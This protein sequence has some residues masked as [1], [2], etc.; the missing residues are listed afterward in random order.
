LALTG[1]NG[2]DRTFEVFSAAR[3]VTWNG[4]AVR[5][6]ATPSG[7]LVGSIPVAATVHLPTL[8]HWRH[9][10]ESPEAAPGFDDS[11]WQVADKTTTN[12]ITPVQ[13]LPVLYA[14]DYGFHTGNIWYRGHFQATGNET[15]VH[16]VSDSGGGAQAFSAWIN[17]QFLGSSTTGSADF[18]FPAG[19]LHQGGDNVISVLTVNMGHEEDYNSTNANKTARGLTTAALLGS[20]STPVTWRIQG[21]LGGEDIQDPVRGPLAY[22]GLFG[23]REGWDLPSYPDTRWA[24]VT[25]PASDT[26]AGVSWYRTSVSLH[27]PPG[28]DTSIGVTFSDNPSRRY[29]ALLYVNGWQLGDYVNYLGPEHSFP[30]PN[31]ILRTDGNNTIAIA[32]WNLD[33]STG[34][35]GQVSLTNYGSYASSLRV[36]PVFSPGYHRV[37][38]ASGRR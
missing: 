5:T 8:T 12:S 37:D 30:I 21:N 3:Q 7:S 1:D 14:D 16:L 25:L 23:E 31:G 9:E 36:G 22:G 13:S 19:S 18:V 35:L 28:Q 33:S 6:T 2:T 27:L 32:V 4:R 29:R 15:G 26:R 38:R 34:G 17:G 11:G 20:P 24:P 10:E